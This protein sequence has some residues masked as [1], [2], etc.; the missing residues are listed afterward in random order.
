MSGGP[1]ANGEHAPGRV[2]RA[3]G[4]KTRPLPGMSAGP[5]ANG[6]HA[7]GPRGVSGGPDANGEQA[8]ACPEGRT[9]TGSRP[10]RVR[11][12]GRER[13]TCPEGRTRMG[14][15]SGGPDANGGRVRRAGREWPRVYSRWPRR[16]A[17]S[18]Y[19]ISIA[20]TWRAQRSRRFT[21]K[22]GLSTLA[23][24]RHRTRASS[25]RTSSR[26]TCVADASPVLTARQRLLRRAGKR[27]L[28]RRIAVAASS[29][30]LARRRRIGRF[31]STPWKT[32]SSS[33]A[34]EVA[35]DAAARSSANES[36]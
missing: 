22:E 7:P 6:E 14:S 36:R 27:H 33:C 29:S 34:V 17:P 26:S 2:R 13:G 35:H 12:A 3:D 25:R 20:D 8:G 1:D 30:R 19:S 32:C 31:S 18:K 5:D 21:G 9:R 23:P 15:V 10:G 11:R 24:G 28:Q 16:R 4:P